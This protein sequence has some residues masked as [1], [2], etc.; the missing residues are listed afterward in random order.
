MAF[1]YADRVMEASSGVGTGAL[2]LSGPIAGFTTFSSAI[3]NTNETYYVITHDTDNTWEVGQGT[4]GA[5]TLARDTVLASSNAGALVNFAAGTKTVFATSAAA[6]Y[7]NAFSLADHASVDHVGITG[8]NDFTSTAHDS[9]DHTGFTGVN[10]FTSAIH[11]GVDHT[12]FTGVPAAEVFTSTA[13]DSV[14]HTGFTGIGLT[15]VQD[16]WFPLGPVS[17]ILKP[18]PEATLPADFVL[19]VIAA[20]NDVFT[21]ELGGTLTTTPIFTTSGPAVRVLDGG[22]AGAVWCNGLGT[23]LTTVGSEVAKPRLVIKASINPTGT[24]GLVDH[25][26]LLGVGNSLN[27]SAEPLNTNPRIAFSHESSNSGPLTIFV[28]R[29]VGVGAAKPDLDTGVTPVAGVPLHFVFEW[30]SSTS[31]TVSILDNAGASLFTTTYT[32]ALEVPI[33]TGVLFHP[34]IRFNNFFIGSGVVG[35]FFGASFSYTR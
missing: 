5:G 13:H 25:G 9:V 19:P 6:F 2:T 33:S 4:V 29:T 7:S 18:N 15:T 27:T 20:G 30:A 3:G 8:V 23:G 26:T 35:H 10:D 17:G 21:S 1:V 31:M 11:S 24:S 34:F 16:L 32:G 28:K 12:G 22:S 14:D